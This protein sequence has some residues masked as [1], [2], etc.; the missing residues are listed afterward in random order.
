MDRIVGNSAQ[1]P[2]GE[3]TPAKE[4]GPGPGPGSATAQPPGPRAPAIAP[5]S[6]SEECLRR[7]IESFAQ[8]LWETSAAGEL[9]ADCPAWRAQTGQSFEQWAGA[10]WLDAIHPEDRAEVEQRWREAVAAGYIIDAEFRLRDAAGGW[11]WTQIWATPIRAPDGAILKWCGMNI[12]IHSR[13][14][15]EDALRKSEERQAFLLKLSDALRPLADP[16]AIQEVAA[17]LL[18]KHIAASRVGY[19]ETQADGETVLVTRHYIDG[20]PGIEGCYRYEDYGPALLRELRA[21]RAVV[22]P[23]VA[24]DP[25]LTDA[26]KRAHAALQLGA[27]VNVPLVKGGRLLAVLF[28]NYRE[29]HAFSADELLLLQD[30]GERTWAA[31]ERARAEAALRES[32]KKYRTLFETMYEGFLVSELVRDDTGQVVNYRHIEVNPALE[33]LTGL[34][35]DAVLGRLGSEVLPDRYTSWMSISERVVA[36]GE[37]IRLEFH[38][39]LLQRWFDISVSPYGADRVIVLYDDITARKQAESVLRK[40]AERQAFLLRLGDAL[41]SLAPADE[42]KAV[43]ARL[44]GQHLASDRVYYAEIEPNDE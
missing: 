9:V 36:S 28:L 35:R 1:Q 4:P 7:L 33:R 22:R 15:T 43:A 21:G 42:I 8:A 26:E 37:P 23:D 25:T 11:R 24:N 38:S 2:A 3:A 39:E 31:V 41:R 32:E 16:V 12:D 40:N 5:V 17:R 18:G 19:A 10:G 27:L 34:R 13:R 29:A 20:V 44:L 6:G 14:R 30:V